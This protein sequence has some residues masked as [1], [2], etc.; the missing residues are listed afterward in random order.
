MAGNV[1]NANNS[2]PSPISKRTHRHAY[3]P[4]PSVGAISERRRRWK[5]DQR[6]WLTP[7]YVHPAGRHHHSLTVHLIRIAI[8]H[9]ELQL[10]FSMGAASAT[11]ALSV[12]S[13][14][15]IS[16]ETSPDNRSVGSRLPRKT[17]CDQLSANSALIY[18]L[19]NDKRTKVPQLHNDRN[20][21]HRSSPSA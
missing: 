5:P 13:L 10:L 20:G 8:H 6:A 21:K 11:N 16:R 15:A 3:R 19:P 14:G 17:I 4:S 9:L 1:T 2:N 7:K 18:S 12:S